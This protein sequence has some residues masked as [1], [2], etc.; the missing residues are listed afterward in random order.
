M[1][2][3]ANF[4]RYTK[5]RPDLATL[6]ALTALNS[7]I[8]SPASHDI[9]GEWGDIRRAIYLY[10]GAALRALAESGVDLSP[11]PVYVDAACR[12]CGGSGEYIHWTG[13]ELDH[14][15]RCGNSGRVR[16]EFIQTTLPN[17]VIWHSPREPL[18]CPDSLRRAVEGMEAR[19]AVDWEIGRPGQDLDYQDLAAAL[20]VAE[21]WYG[22]PGLYVIKW[23]YNDPCYYKLPLG[24]RPMTCSFCDEHVSA[25][26][27]RYCA[28]DD[29]MRWGDWCCP[30]CEKRFDLEFP[31]FPFPTELVTEAAAIWLERRENWERYRPPGREPVSPKKSPMFD[32]VQQLGFGLEEI[33]F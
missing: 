1:G 26:A 21:A 18:K 11:V 19:P 20:N 17:G 32:R 13:Q 9:G 2:I 6:T 22:V 14:C 8:R 31:A 4:E 24:D 25:D 27:M 30:S 29:L 33:P 28:G 7:W 5:G 3:T 12:D 10:K 23:D 15:W 16:L